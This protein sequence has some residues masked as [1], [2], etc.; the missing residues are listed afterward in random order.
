MKKTLIILDFDHTVFN[1]TKFVVALK[2]RF[3]DEFGIDDA[4]FMIARNEV[5]QCC[6]VID[7]DRFV[8]LLPHEDKH[9]MHQ[10][11][12]DVIESLGKTFV[13]DDVKPFFDRMK[14]KADIVIATHGDKELQTAK[15]VNSDLPKVPFEI[16]LEDKDTVVEKYEAQYDII[17]FVDDKA[18]NVDQVKKEHPEVITYF[19]QRPED[20]PYADKVSQC[21][22]VDRVIE[23]LN[24][25]VV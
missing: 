20:K 1:T 24:E 8:H 25:I 17:H 11:I 19:M 5:K 22:Y 15:I 10:A 3:W 13:F 12:V 18:K 4:T 14:G 21:A 23:S 9:G 2:K 16:S 6:V 7:I